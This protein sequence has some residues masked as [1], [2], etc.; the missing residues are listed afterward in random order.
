MTKKKIIFKCVICVLLV[1]IIALQ[2]FALDFIVKVR[3]DYK[4]DT[5]T[6][7]P[8]YFAYDLFSEL[9]VKYNLCALAVALSIFICLCVIAFEVRFIFISLKQ[10][11]LQ[12]QLSEMEKTE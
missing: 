8:D 2:I 11:K 3:N 10:A 5:D 4:F 7:G 1:L 6:A 12:K 9:V